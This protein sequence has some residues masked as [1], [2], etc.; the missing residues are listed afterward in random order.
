MKRCFRALRDRV[1]VKEL[2][3]DEKT[4]SG[5]IFVP[6]RARDIPMRGTVMAVGEGRFTESGHNIPVGVEIGETVYYG[7]YSGTEIQLAGSIVKVLRTDELV[8]VDFEAE[9]V[10][11]GAWHVEVPTDEEDESCAEVV[12]VSAEDIQRIAGLQ[13]EAVSA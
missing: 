11:A 3:L 13:D 9:E 2:P 5:R 4:L 1:V 8:G 10:P 12:G 7:K 6:E